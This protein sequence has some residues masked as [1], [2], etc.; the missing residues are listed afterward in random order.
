[1]VGTIAYSAYRNP[2]V[3]QTLEDNIAI[4]FVGGFPTASKERDEKDKE[5]WRAWA[6]KAALLYYRPNVFLYS[7]S[8]FGFPTVVLDRTIRDFRF[9]AENKCVGLDVDSVFLNYATQGPQLYLM[10]QLAYDPLQDGK[11]LL[12]DYFRRGFGPAA[13][14]I[15]AYF[16]LLEDSQEEILADENYTSG[17]GARL[18]LFEVYPRVYSENFFQRG[19]AY[20]EDAEKKTLEGPEVYRERVAFIRD[21]YRFLKTQVELIVELAKVRA[22]GEEAGTSFEKAVE[23][24]AERDRLM[25]ESRPFALD[26]R[27]IASRLQ[28]NMLNYLGPPDDNLLSAA[29][30]NDEGNVPQYLLAPPEWKP[31]FSDNFQRAELGPNWE[32]ID[33]TW[34]IDNGAIVTTSGGAIAI[35]ASFSGLQKIEFEARA[36]TE[37][38]ASGFGAGTAARPSDLS[39]SLHNPGHSPSRQGYF[40]QFGGRFNTVNAL[41]KAGTEVQKSVEYLIDPQRTHRISAEVN[42]TSVRLEVDGNVLIDWEESSP[43]LGEENDRI[44]FYFFQPARMQSVRVFTAEPKLIPNPDWDPLLHDPDRE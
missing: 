28:G 37:G 40:L 17:S 26:H 36:D 11:A 32:V 10:A 1:M 20:L 21:G 19:N 34:S 5:Q 7:G 39:V 33:G 4:G 13:L 16:K 42:N 44:V 29:T 31:A 23:L 8:D 38:P 9:L 25:Q 14:E 18:K 22:G 35:S 30:G 6:D 41:R 24:S 12:E 3:G 27:R 2:P 15:E 43:L